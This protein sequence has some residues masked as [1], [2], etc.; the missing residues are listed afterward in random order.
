MVLAGVGHIGRWSVP[1]LVGLAVVAALLSPTATWSA[2]FATQPPSVTLEDQSGRPITA[3]PLFAGLVLA[4]GHFEQ[5]T[6]VARNEG[7]S[8]ATLRVAARADTDE[9]G[10]LWTRADGLQARLI[11]P[12]SGAAL[13]E[14]PLRDLASGAA[15]LLPPGDA[16]TLLLSVGLPNQADPSLMGE[17]LSVSFVF[18]VTQ[19]L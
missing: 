17:Q 10:G 11:D 8:P 16:T 3:A 6:V 19:A 15:A 5:R 2:E 12:A 4:P 18:E 9:P 7:T 13:Y 14:G 1:W